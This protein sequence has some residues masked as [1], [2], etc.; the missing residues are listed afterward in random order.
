MVDRVELLRSIKPGIGPWYWPKCILKKFEEE[1]KQ[2]L[3]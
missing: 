2:N 1:E 3:L